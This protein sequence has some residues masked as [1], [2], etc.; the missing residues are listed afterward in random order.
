M[1]KIKKIKNINDFIIN[2]NIT[3]NGI[4]DYSKSEYKGAREKITIICPEGHEFTQSPNDHLNGH[5]CKICSGWGQ[6]LDRNKFIKRLKN[7]YKDKYDFSESVYNGWEN[8]FKIGCKIHGEIMV[9]PSN[10]IFK[11]TGCPKCG[12]DNR[13]HPS[14][15][16]QEEFI[17]KAKSIHGD[18]YD[19][20]QVEYKS[21]TIRIKIICPKHGLFK[22]QPKEH[23]YQKQGCPSCYSSK[24]ENKIREFL[25]SNLISFIQQHKFKECKNKRPLPFDFYI[26][27]FNICIEF[28]GIQHYF[29]V[30]RFGG[31]EHLNYIKHKDKIK[32]KFCIENNIKLIRIKYNQMD[33]IDQILTEQL[34]LI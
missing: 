13:Y 14:T 23:I 17:L 29:P 22:Q 1:E 28:D 21:A 33:K 4:F 30:E 24:G 11:K 15:L 32:N 31:I 34:N 25:T 12:F 7:I 6:M 27:D 18:K 5:G 20:S 16:S 26:P 2:A 3:H 8:P 10:F 19:Y 9:R